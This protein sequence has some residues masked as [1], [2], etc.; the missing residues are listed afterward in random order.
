MVSCCC[1]SID[2]VRLRRLATQKYELLRTAHLS[3]GDVTKYL[4]KDLKIPRLFAYYFSVPNVSSQG[5]YSRIARSTVV[6]R[7]HVVEHHSRLAHAW[8]GFHMG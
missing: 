1:L 4:T 6:R 3:I 8:R 2:S 5:V 7:R